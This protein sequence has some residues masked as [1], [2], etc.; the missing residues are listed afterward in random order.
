MFIVSRLIGVGTFAYFL[1]MFCLL[2]ARTR[3]SI[4]ALLGWYTVVLAVMGFF[5]EPYITADLY[6]I[7]EMMV[8]F[9]ALDLPAFIRTYVVTSAVPTARMLYWAVGKSGVLGLLPAIACLVSYGC[10]FHI[11]AD[12]ARRRESSRADVAATL[13]FIMSVGQYMSAVSNI[14]TMMAVALVCFCA[15]REIAEKKSRWWHLALYAA[16]ATLHTFGLVAIVLRLMVP[17]L[18][19]G[20]PLRGRVCLALVFLTAFAGALIVVPNLAAELM[21]KVE[22]YILGDSYSYF[23]DYL[24]GFIAF[25]I[26][27]WLLWL[28][29]GTP[30]RIRL[31]LLPAL[32]AATLFCFEFSIFHRLVTYVCPILTGPLMLGALRG[33]AEIPDGRIRNR[34]TLILVLSLCMLAVACSRGSL[35]SFK[36]F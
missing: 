16:A 5:Y 1:L 4:R 25:G 30:E 21:E 8:T 14:R 11:L 36:F 7:R 15:Y 29:R 13:F 35:C 9:S 22:D 10:I 34:Q 27:V 33:G 26:Q 2:I 17:V 31:M 32:G 3:I 19:P 24:I 23:W 20:L 18:D 6:R 12:A 28:H